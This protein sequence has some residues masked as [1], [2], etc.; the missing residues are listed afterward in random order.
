MKLVVVLFVCCNVRE[1]EPES[2]PAGSEV[3]LR[4]KVGVL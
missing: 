1:Q 2:P 4:M 3:C